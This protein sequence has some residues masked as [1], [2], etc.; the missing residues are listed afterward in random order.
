MLQLQCIPAEM[1]IFWHCHNVIHFC[2]LLHSSKG[3]F[4]INRKAMCA[5]KSLFCLS[6]SVFETSNLFVWTH[7]WRDV[8]TV[9]TE[10]R[11]IGWRVH[12]LFSLH[13]S[14]SFNSGKLLCLKKSCH[15]FVT[16]SPRWHLQQITSLVE[17]KKGEKP[18]SHV[19]FP[20]EKVWEDPTHCL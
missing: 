17:K 18:G 12:I 6:V 11:R 15:Y 1:G 8:R 19:F 16:Q 20:L 4:K 13:I 10:T 7:S 3:S 14:C 9:L 5:V 2:L